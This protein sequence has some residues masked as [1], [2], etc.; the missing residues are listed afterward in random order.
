MNKSKK[1]AGAP[2]PNGLDGSHHS[3]KYSPSPPGT[4]E[5][6]LFLHIDADGKEVWFETPPKGLRSTKV[7]RVNGYEYCR[8]PMITWKEDSAEIHRCGKPPGK[9]WHYHRQD[10]NGVEIRD[11]SVAP[12][13]RA[14]QRPLRELYK[15]RDWSRLWVG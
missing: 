1:P 6:T 10:H 14:T 4:K 2:T 13:R 15:P 11:E 7:I 5:E 8:K 12:Y 9:G 3:N